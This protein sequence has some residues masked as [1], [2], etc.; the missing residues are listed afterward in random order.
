[1]GTKRHTISDRTGIPLALLLSGANVHDS[2][3]HYWMWTAL[4]LSP[5][6]K[7]AVA[8]NACEDK[9]YDYPECRADLQALGYIIHIPHRGEE[10]APQPDEPRYPARRWVI[11]RTGSWQN[12]FRRLKIRHEVKAENYLGFVQFANAIICFRSCHDQ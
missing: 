9:G 6:D 11:E 4:L 1:M 12:M 10:N 5:P 7:S 3:M 8:Q 2:Q